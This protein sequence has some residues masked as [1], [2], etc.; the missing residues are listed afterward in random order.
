MDKLNK[1]NRVI[2]NDGE[3]EL[4]VSVVGETLWLTQKQ[5]QQI[6]LCFREIGYL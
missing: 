1:S 4:D 5:N 6:R 3:L 2:Y